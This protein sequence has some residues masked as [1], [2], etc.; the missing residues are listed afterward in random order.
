V[1]VWLG[2]SD[3]AFTLRV[4]VHLLGDGLG[5]PDSLDEAEWAQRQAAPAVETDPS[6]RIANTA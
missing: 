4:Y 1:Q 5:D 2:H 6:G 3:P